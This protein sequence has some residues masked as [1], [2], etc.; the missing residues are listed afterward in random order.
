[1]GVLF[2]LGDTVLHVER[3]DAAAGNRR[4]LEFATNKPT[5]TVEQIQA[6]ADEIYADIVKAQRQTQTEFPAENFDRLLYESLGISLSITPA[7]MAREFH[8]A[9]ITHNPAPGIEAVLETLKSHGIKAGIVSNT[10]FTG[11]ILWEELVAHNLAHYFEFVVASSDFG[12]RKPNPRIFMIAAAK[13]RLRPEEIWFVGDKI[14]FDIAGAVKSGMFPV[15]YNPSGTPRTGDYECL[16]IKH[17]DAFRSRIDSLLAP[18][19]RKETGD[20]A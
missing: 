12:F 13:M 11:D 7:E 8:R 9:A 18:F 2:D 19:P 10:M 5:V 3:A 1:L 4:L 16:E 15:W 6:A 14:D 17:W 20:G